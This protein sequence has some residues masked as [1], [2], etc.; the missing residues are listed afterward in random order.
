MKFSFL[1]NGVIVLD[2]S[3]KLVSENYEGP[4]LLPNPTGF[5]VSEEIRKPIE[6]C[7]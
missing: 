6:D 3:N 1:S 7:F 4:M 5:S 2:F